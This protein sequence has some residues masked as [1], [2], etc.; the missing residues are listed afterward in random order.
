MQSIMIQLH[1]DTMHVISLN[2]NNSTNITKIDSVAFIT[3]DTRTVVRTIRIG[4]RRQID[5]AVVMERHIRL[6]L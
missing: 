1:V 6:H 4:T 3:I 2:M 5:G